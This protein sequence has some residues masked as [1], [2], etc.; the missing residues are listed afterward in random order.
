MPARYGLKTNTGPAHFVGFR[1]PFFANPQ[2][3]V[4]SGRTSPAHRAGVSTRK[5]RGF[6]VLEGATKRVR[7][8]EGPGPQTPGPSVLGVPTRPLNVKGNRG[9]HLIIG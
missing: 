3:F 4:A 9:T 8:R 1:T 2:H 5:N 6:G 7:K